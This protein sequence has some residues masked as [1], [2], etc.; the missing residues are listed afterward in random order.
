MLLPEASEGGP[1]IPRSYRLAHGWGAG[2][3]ARPFPPSTPNNATTRHHQFR[4]KKKTNILTMVC[5]TLTQD[6]NTA[7][8]CSLKPQRPTSPPL[9]PSTTHASRLSEDQAPSEGTHR[10]P[11]DHRR[12]TAPP[13]SQ[14]RRRHLLLI[15]PTAYLLEEIH[16]KTRHHG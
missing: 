9:C 3:V 2:V 6:T 14:K 15:R 13:S 7:K 16:R 10:L 8:R 4:F 5:W 12:P 1:C 11:Y